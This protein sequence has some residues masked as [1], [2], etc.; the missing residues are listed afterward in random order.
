MSHEHDFQL[1]RETN[2]PLL[3]HRA[4]LH[5]EQEKGIFPWQLGF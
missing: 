2:I 5:W 4:G 1:Q 3:K